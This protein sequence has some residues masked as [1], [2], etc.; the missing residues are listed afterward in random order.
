MRWNIELFSA[1]ATLKTMLGNDAYCEGINCSKAAGYCEIARVSSAA[2][3]VPRSPGAP[4]K[5]SNALATLTWFGEMAK[6]W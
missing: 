4:M 2:L 3:T 1:L 5:V 6:D